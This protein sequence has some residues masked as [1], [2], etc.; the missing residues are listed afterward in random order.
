MRADQ[1]FLRRNEG[2]GA[3]FSRCPCPRGEPRTGPSS[4]PAPR[5]GAPHPWLILGKSEREIG[6]GA[7]FV[8]R[9]SSGVLAA[10]QLQRRLDLREQRLDFGGLVRA[11]IVVE[12]P[13]QL[14]LLIQELRNSRQSLFSAKA[15][16]TSKGPL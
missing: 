5:A 7:L 14:L 8:G 4:P 12:A 9:V 3:K 6:R 1:T 16:M 11:R 10:Q 2:V 15:S 13:E